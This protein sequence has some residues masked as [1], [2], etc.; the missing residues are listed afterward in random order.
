M[1]LLL[2][3]CQPA[4]DPLP[5]KKVDVISGRSLMDIT[6]WL[7]G[8]FLKIWMFWA[9]PRLQIEGILQ[10]P[11]YC[12]MWIFVRFE[13]SWGSEAAWETIS[14][15]L[16]SIL[17]SQTLEKHSRNFE[18]CEIWNVCNKRCF[19][20]IADLTIAEAWNETYG[21]CFFAPEARRSWSIFWS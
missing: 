18:K 2:I 15:R 5:P 3:F 7:L 11:L 19:Y 20:R 10:I 12:K 17:G 14:R 6:L 21:Y 8:W 1:R 9:S 16:W 13:R 4:P